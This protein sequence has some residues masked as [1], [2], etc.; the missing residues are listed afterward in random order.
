M[1]CLQRI[2]QRPV[3]MAMNRRIREQASRVDFG[4]AEES[5]VF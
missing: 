5:S 3:N 1:I 2:L 4:G